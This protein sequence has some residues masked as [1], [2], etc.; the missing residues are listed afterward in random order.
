MR[1]ERWNRRGIRWTL[2]PGLLTSVAA[3][4]TLVLSPA[5]AIEEA[6]LECEFPTGTRLAFAGEASPFELGLG[7]ENETE[8]T[9]FYITAGPVDRG[10][11]LLR[12]AWRAAWRNGVGRGGTCPPIGRHR[13]GPVRTVVDH[14]FEAGSGAIVPRAL[15]SAIGTGVS[16]DSRRQAAESAAEAKGSMGTMSTSV[17]ESKR[18]SAHF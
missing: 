11:L 17:P 10:H 9:R 6:P 18:R 16:H 2:L 13:P 4:G 15:E 1:P 5:P 12:S 3:C 7:L 8:R 14:D